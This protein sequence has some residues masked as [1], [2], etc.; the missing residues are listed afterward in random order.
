MGQGRGVR[1]KR[2]NLRSGGS[3]GRRFLPS[4]EVYAEISAVIYGGIA[5]IGSVHFVMPDMASLVYAA[6]TFAHGLVMQ[7]F[8][9]FAYD[10]Q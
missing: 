9:K 8:F 6:F 10:N 1:L 3:A 5:V 4:G 2:V 7:F